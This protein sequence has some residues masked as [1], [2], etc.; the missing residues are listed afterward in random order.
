VLNAKVEG[1][2][3]AQFAELVKD[4]ELNC[5]ISR[6]LNMEIGVEYTLNT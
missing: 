6:A 1:I 5:P 4:A 3:D 2:S